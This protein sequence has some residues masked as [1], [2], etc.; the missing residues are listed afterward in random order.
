MYKKILKLAIVASAISTHA[1]AMNSQAT[2]CAAVDMPVER[3]HKPSS[4]CTRI[5]E[6]NFHGVEVMEHDYLKA[7]DLFIANPPPGTPNMQTNPGG[8]VSKLLNDC[9]ASCERPELASE[10]KIVAKMMAVCK[11]SEREWKKFSQQ[12]NAEKSKT[13]VK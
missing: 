8:Q 6:N 7:L 5:C 12:H 4:N 2:K 1:T 10:F 9:F 3:Q 13:P 11:S